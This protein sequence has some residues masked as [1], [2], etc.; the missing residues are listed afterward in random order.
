M[1]S[2]KLRYWTDCWYPT[3]SR[4]WI[5]PNMLLAPTYSRDGL[6]RLKLSHIGQVERWSPSLWKRFLLKWKR[7]SFLTERATVQ[8]RLFPF[9]TNPHAAVKWT[10]QPTLIKC[11]THIFVIV[12]NGSVATRSCWGKRSGD[13][14][15]DVVKALLHS[16][17]CFYRHVRELAVQE[18]PQWT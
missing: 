16:S 9:S 3:S 5:S 14:D 7:P 12:C 17:P 1:R 10:K 2:L 6:A 11:V 15:D 18:G 13:D 4:Y 8:E